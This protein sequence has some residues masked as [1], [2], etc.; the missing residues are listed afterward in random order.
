MPNIT[1]R[2]LAAQIADELN[3]NGRNLNQLDIVEI[4]QVIVREVTRSLAS[5]K[6]VMLR[7]F[8]VFHIHHSKAKIGRNPKDPAKIVP[9]PS[10]PVVKFRPGK[11]LKESMAN[12]N[13]RRLPVKRMSK[14]AKKSPAK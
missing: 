2:E 14:S 6:H 1:K 11:E 10:R 3:R 7:N 12:S 4:L 5:G 8:G 9:I 13:I